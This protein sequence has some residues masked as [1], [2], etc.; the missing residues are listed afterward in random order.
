MDPEP[1]GQPLL[2]LPAQFR[3]FVADGVRGVGGRAHGEARQDRLARHRAERAALGDLDGRGQRLRNVG[4]QHRHFRAGLEAVIRRQLLAIGFGDQASAG[5]AE[6]RVMG[7]VIVGGGE[8]RLVGRNQRQ[9]LGVGEIDQP[10]LGAALLLDAVAL[11]F[12]IEPVA[13]QACQPVAAR[14]RQR[15]MVGI[16]RQRDRP[17]R[18]AGQRDQILGVVLAAIRA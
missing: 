7:F 10:G 5:D 1:V 11:Q 14:R 17:L 6:Q 16:D 15:R 3:G 13:E 9:A 8:M 2:G 12:D 4:E 18:A